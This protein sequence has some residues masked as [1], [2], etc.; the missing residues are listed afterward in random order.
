M[1][2]SREGLVWL[3]IMVV[4]RLYIPEEKKLK[5][6]IGVVMATIISTLTLTIQANSGR[7]VLAGLG[8]LILDLEAG[9]QFVLCICE[10]TMRAVAREKKKER[11][12]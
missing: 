5:I 7:T 6:Y 8:R 9:P 4:G 10:E 1:G 2:C 3:C 11:R 12:I